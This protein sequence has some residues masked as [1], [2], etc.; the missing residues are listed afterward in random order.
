MH[1]S[2]IK[3]YMI[4][5]ISTL[6]VCLFIVN[7]AC[8]GDTCSSAI[9]LV[10]DMSTLAPEL[11]LKPISEKHGLAFENVAKMYLAAGR[12]R[13]LI[14]ADVEIRASHIVKLNQLFKSGNVKIKKEIGTRKFSTG[15]IYKY[16]VFHF[17]EKNKTIEARFFEDHEKLTDDELK[18]LGIKTAEDKR[19]FFSPGLEGV[20]FSNFVAPGKDLKIEDYLGKEPFM[21]SLQLKGCHEASIEL[22]EQSVLDGHIE[23][24]GIRDIIVVGGT[25]E[26]VEG[27]IRILPGRDL[28]VGNLYFKP[29]EDILGSLDL[30]QSNSLRLIRLDASRLDPARFPDN[31]Y[32][33][34][35]MSGI[36]P[37][38]Y[39]DPEGSI[40]VK[41][42]DLMVQRI[43]EQALRVV[44]P[45]GN[46]FDGSHNL[47]QELYQQLIKDGYIEQIGYGIYR[48]TEKSFTTPSTSVENEAKRIHEENMKPEHMPIISEKA[49]L[50]EIMKL[51][52]ISAA[53]NLCS[54]VSIALKKALKKQGI[55]AVVSA[56]H[57]SRAPFLDENGNQVVHYWVETPD[58]VLD[59]FPEGLGKYQDQVVPYKKDGLVII[60][61]GTPLPLIYAMSR[62]AT[63]QEL[64]FEYIE[65]EKYELQNRDTASQPAGMALKTDKTVLLHV[66]ANSIIP[67][68][69]RGMM[70]TL[71]QDM[72]GEEYS[73]KVV[74]L[75]VRDTAT[76]EEF[77]SKLE[78]LKARE[79]A[80]YQ[81]KGYA[82]QFDVACPNTEL[83]SMIQKD[84]GL[85]ALAF[86]KSGEGDIVQVE[87]II[88]AL[89]ALKTGNMAT[90]IDI[91]EF[92]TGETLVVE[93]TDINE[94]AR[95]VIFLLPVSKLDVNE[96]VK[97]NEI[98]KKNI[99]TAA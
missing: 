26:E 52:Q 92:L 34:W 21:T 6:V 88:L 57:N 86:N 89:R 18:E 96:I 68:T 48:R 72:R 31:S 97:L 11:R 98:I 67:E 3:P 60:K 23:G 65:D 82:V 53:G 35:F 71:E 25:Q 50:S 80:R 55:D 41:E 62:P 5:A 85:P 32:D 81:E 39:D 43:L 64:G 16:A 83:V 58:H 87:S 8:W 59:A 27:L 77:L 99:K 33:L 29:L 1:R 70:K 14:D 66:V 47:N 17:E 38:T 49:S 28:T 44:R 42:M 20:W 10:Q 51:V 91:Y 22:L 13:K 46:I 54:G 90:L 15:K 2:Q 4:K 79:K 12:I 63:K 56:S 45:G 7:Q 75:S 73:E 36:E 19:Y 30:A 84:L 94:L 78:Q 69:Q 76:P 61:K 93:T 24:E 9:A 74:C 95:S 40:P 37:T